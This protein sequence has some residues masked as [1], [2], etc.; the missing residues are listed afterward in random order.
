MKNAYGIIFKGIAVGI[1]YG[2]SHTLD[3]QGNIKMFTIRNENNEVI[4]N[5][6][7]RNAEV[8]EEKDQEYRS[9]KPYKVIIESI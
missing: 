6:S 3:G 5:T 2:D 8:I 9:I 7:C 4:Y 1:V